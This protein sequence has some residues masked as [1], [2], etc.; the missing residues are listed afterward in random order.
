ML[1]LTRRPMQTLKIGNSVTITVLEIRGSQVRLGV[2]AP[3][4]IAVHRGETF[5]ASREQRRI[6]D[7]GS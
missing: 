3:R 5:D 1:V 4:D 6:P 7:G 2:D